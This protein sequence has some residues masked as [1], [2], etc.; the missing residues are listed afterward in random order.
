MLVYLGDRHPD[1]KLAP[2]PDDADAFRTQFR[3][4]TRI[5]SAVATRPAVA[6][7]LKRH[8]R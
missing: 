7:A 3:N 6:R 4:V 1:A 2:A 8:R 5:T